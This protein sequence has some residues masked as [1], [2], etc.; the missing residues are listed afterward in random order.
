[1]V[2]GVL[3]GAGRGVGRGAEGGPNP[4]S[5]PSS[6][7]LR[8]RWSELEGR[9]RCVSSGIIHGRIFK[10]FVTRVKTLCVI[11]EAVIP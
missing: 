3:G 5:T 7:G 1:M 11:I 9:R 2:G 8:G 10:S 6:C 4:S